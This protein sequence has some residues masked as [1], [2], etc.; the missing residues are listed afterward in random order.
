[1]TAQKI[2]HRGKAGERSMIVGSDRVVAVR[3]LASSAPAVA[4]A[5]VRSSAARVGESRAA[6]RHR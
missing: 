4:R 6:V 5:M 2:G 3:A 1:M